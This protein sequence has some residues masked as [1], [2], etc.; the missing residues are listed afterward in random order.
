MMLSCRYIA[1]NERAGYPS[2]ITGRNV[3]ESVRC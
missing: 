2:L 3:Y 1:G